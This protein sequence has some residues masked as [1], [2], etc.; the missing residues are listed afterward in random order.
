[1]RPGADRKKESIPVRVHTLRA[2]SGKQELFSRVGPRK[3][4]VS[5]EMEVL[6]FMCDLA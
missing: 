4:F 6:F 5:M 2:S 1:M 3:T